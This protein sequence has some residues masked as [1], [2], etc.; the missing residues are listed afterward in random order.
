MSNIYILP[1]SQLF[2]APIQKPHTLW[3]QL[4]SCNSFL[5]LFLV[6]SYI[7]TMYLNHI[8][9]SC[10]ILQ[11]FVDFPLHPPLNFMS[12]FC[13]CCCCL[14]AHQIQLV[15]YANDCRTT[16]PRGCETYHWP[17]LWETG[18]HFPRGHQLPRSPQLYFEPP[19]PVT[20]PAG[21]S[22]MDL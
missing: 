14:I 17:H 11:L 13:C 8:N 3:R 15:L 10:L 21:K 2:N 22:A 20:T 5:N 6:M 1:C 4:V 16:P 12:S 19:V 7:N 18:S 9:P